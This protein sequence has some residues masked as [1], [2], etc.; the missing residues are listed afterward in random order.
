MKVALVHDWLT[1]MR[2][3]ERVLEEFCRL[4]PDASLFTLVYKPGSVSGRI[5][6]LSPRT[7]FLN[8]IPGASRHYRHLLPLFPW[9][10][11]RFDLRGFDLVLSVS[12]AAA[13]G[14]RKPPRSLH[15][16]YCLTPMRYI[17]DMQDDY[18]RYA[19]QLGIKRAMLRAAKHPLRAWDR[20]TACGVD[21]FIADSRHVQDRISRYYCRDARVIYPPVDTA[22]FTPGENGNGAGYFLVVSALVPY[23][24]VDIA[25][26][27]FNR[28]G[29]ALVVAGDG[30][31]LDRLRQKAFGNIRFVG[32][33]T[34]E[35]LRELYRHCRAVINTAREDFGLVSLEAQACCRP[36]VAYGAGGSLESISDGETGI[37]FGS[38]T[39]AGLIDGIRR[40]EKTGFSPERL[41]SNAERFS[42][43][44]FRS[45]I[46]RFIGEKLETAHRRARAPVAGNSAAPAG[47]YPRVVENAGRK[48]PSMRGVPGIAKRALDIAVSLFG[49]LLLGLPLLLVAILIRR[50]SSGPA[51]FFQSRVGFRRLNFVMV[52]LRTMRV[53]AE[54]RSGPAWAVEDDPRCTR[55]GGF[56][57]TYGIDEILQLWNVL[58]GEMS[59]VGP[60]P[61]RPEF[62]EIF[63]ASFPEFRRRLEV[64]GGMTGLAQV[65]G[66]RGDTSIEERLRADLEYI[67][68]WS[69]W[70]DL[71]ILVRT[72]FSLVRRPGRWSRLR[73]SSRASA[74]D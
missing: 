70:K 5:E 63:E 30:P 40:L 25:V 21:H 49:L 26:E 39:V 43:A 29:Y 53:D 8:R 67:G 50:D 9:A 22:F 3:G 18:F 24:R 7:S 57:R 20:A 66:W 51:L 4:F 15:V 34:N 56:L 64:R 65:R 71:M 62:Q 1:G 11:S 45:E 52:K 16:C 42:S 41:R 74:S 33:V 61:E 54:L 47:F 12:H 60:R 14:V 68:H 36:P 46:L 72:P 17:W 19:D 6:S 32:H 10:V 55:I 31:D 27:A 35:E 28:L 37:L 44:A 2:G 23:K 58:K 38:Q 73:A 13:K 59:L 69:L 48:H